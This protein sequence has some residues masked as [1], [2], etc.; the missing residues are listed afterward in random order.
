M[1][2]RNPLPPCLSHLAQREAKWLQMPAPRSQRVL[3]QTRSR[4]V[5]IAIQVNTQ[6]GWCWRADDNEPDRIEDDVVGKDRSHVVGM[7]GGAANQGVDV[8]QDSL[9]C[10]AL[11]IVSADVG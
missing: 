9:H 5:E 11:V 8:E 3:V 4:V 10:A 7:R 6:I 2:V 1:S